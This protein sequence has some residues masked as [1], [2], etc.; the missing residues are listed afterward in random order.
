M[1]KTRLFAEKHVNWGCF[2]RIMRAFW[3]KSMNCAIKWP[4]AAENLREEQ[5]ASCLLFFPR[6]LTQVRAGRTILYPGASGN[7]NI[8]AFL[9]WALSQLGLEILTTKGRFDEI[10]PC[11]FAI[12]YFC[13]NDLRRRLRA[14]PVHCV[15]QID[16]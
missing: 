2:A 14:R 13:A 7:K 1:P 6:T 4:R 15:N 9:P 5:P 8:T 11:P 3:P 16:R 10:D 12:P